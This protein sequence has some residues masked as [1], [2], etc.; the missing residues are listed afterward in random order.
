MG[1]DFIL[2]ALVVRL[3]KVFGEFPDGYALTGYKATEKILL[4]PSAGV[5]PRFFPTGG[6]MRRLRCG[7]W[8]CS[9]MGR[10]SFSFDGPKGCIGRAESPVQASG[11][12][13]FAMKIS[14][15]GA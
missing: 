6:M 15:V 1:A 4:T 10:S 13:N 9:P 2:G 8:A 5:M 12:D 3:G 14:L 11:C 7:S